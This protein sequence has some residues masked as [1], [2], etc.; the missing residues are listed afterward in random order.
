V[1]SSYRNK[2]WITPA[3]KCPNCDFQ[4]YGVF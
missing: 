1:I 2:S 3:G 4:I